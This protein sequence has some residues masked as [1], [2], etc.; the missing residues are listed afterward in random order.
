MD[1]ALCNRCR[2]RCF[3]TLL[4]ARFEM[5]LQNANVPYMQSS[6]D[7]KCR[8]GLM[9]SAGL[10]FLSLPLPFPHPFASETR[11]VM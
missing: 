5:A 8:R 4:T 11:H 3:F 10:T 6:E 2:A 7:E 1:G 9:C